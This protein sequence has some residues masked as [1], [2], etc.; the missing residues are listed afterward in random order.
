MAGI[1]FMHGLSRA[2]AASG[3]AK[4]ENKT[5]GL[6]ID[7]RGDTRRRLLKTQ[8]SNGSWQSTHP[9]ETHPTLTTSFAV[10]ALCGNK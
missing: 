7:W 1:Y 9:W 2:A 4:L 5:K 8:A 6:N 3:K 10:L